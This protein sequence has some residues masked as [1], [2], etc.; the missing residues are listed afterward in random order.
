MVFDFYKLKIIKNFKNN[1]NLY[2]TY[3]LSP[4]NITI[5]N[6]SSIIFVNTFKN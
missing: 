4:N 6:N 5:K 3:L 1:E 2:K